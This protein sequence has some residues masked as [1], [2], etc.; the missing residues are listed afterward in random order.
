MSCFYYPGT[1]LKIL[2][3]GLKYEH[4]TFHL[5]YYIY[6]IKYLKNTFYTAIF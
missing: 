4:Y 2:N 5:I 6:S 1:K 3:I